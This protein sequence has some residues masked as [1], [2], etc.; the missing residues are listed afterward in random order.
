MKLLAALVLTVQIAGGVLP[1]SAAV[2]AQ[3]TDGSVR[4][5]VRAD[6]KRPNILWI[7][8]E[9]MNSSLGSYGDAEA[10]TPHL[11]KLAREGVRF[12]NAFSVAGVCAPSRSSLATGMY[13]TTIGSHHMRSLAVP[14]PHV[15][16]FS[17]YLRAAGYYTTNNAKTDY[18]FD[19]PGAPPPV[20]AWDE[21]SNRAHWRNRPAGK[22]FFSVFSLMM[23][24]ESKIRAD[25]KEFAE[26]TAGLKPSD[27]HDPARAQ[28][29]PY[30][31]D[32]PAT[33]R[34]WARHYDLITAMDLRAGELL[35]ELHDD[36]LADETIVFFFSDNGRGL[37]RAKRWVYDAGIHLPLIVR[38]PNRLQPGT[39]NNDLVSFVDLPPTV[40]SL[41]G[42]GAPA[43]MQGQI[44]LG[45]E[46]SRRREYIFAARDRMDE[47]YDIIRGV[48]DK[49]YK[50]IRNFQPQKPYAQFIQYAEQMPT[51]Q[52]MRRLYKES[53]AGPEDKLTPAQKLFF[54]PEKPDE[55]LYDTLSDPHE[56]NNLARSMRHRRLL[57][58]M[59]M[60]LRRWRNETKDLGL[61]PEAELKERMR[62]GGVWAVTAEPF[63]KMKNTAAHSPANLKVSSPTSGASIVYTTEEGKDARWQLY[64]KD[65][66]FNR[67]AVVRIKAC[68]LGYRDSKEVTVRLD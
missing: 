12:T 27:R 55:E 64:S 2:P 26:L 31:P 46:A 59:R 18:N 22:P 29:P 43:H 52:E 35:K 49:R 28:L 6:A 23:S 47:T 57:V 11:D 7:I 48:R 45:P 56:I 66:I 24:H 37:P 44:F 5:G 50:Y 34:D 61:I 13:P 51:L 10:R 53:V 67:P 9:D 60:A 42:V 30:Y 16:I 63:V 41:A 36:G 68:R 8:A 39:V 14:P 17:E 15:K 21:S 62:P 58:R 20:A 1:T 19:R 54:L 32:T 65:I 33:R 40:L 3:K 25:E 4:A 38:W